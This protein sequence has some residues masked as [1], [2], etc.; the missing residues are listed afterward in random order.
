MKPDVPV[1]QS[2]FLNRVCAGFAKRSKA[3]GSWG[4]L[5]FHTDSDDDFEWVSIFYQFSNWPSV[6]L[7]LVEDQRMS[8][9]VRRTTRKR[10]GE[11]LVSLRDLYIVDDPSRILEL[12][13]WTMD[14]LHLLNSP[15][16]DMDLIN[17]IKAESEKLSFKVY[18]GEEAGEAD[19][20]S[21]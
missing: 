17:S 16:V 12:F 7:Q 10:G 19:G 6:E 15:V 2:D 8:L 13:E 1:F 20:G 21:P 4:Q 9:F 3:F 14:K 5:S 11:L 18:R